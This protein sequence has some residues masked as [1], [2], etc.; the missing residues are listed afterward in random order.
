MNIPDWINSNYIRHQKEQEPQ[1]CG[2]IEEL[3]Q[4]DEEPISAWE[5]LQMI[6]LVIAIWFLLSMAIILL[7]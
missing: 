5:I 3:K 7:T 1:S 6:L 2:Q 4:S